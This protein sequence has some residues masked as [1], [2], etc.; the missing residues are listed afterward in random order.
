[1]LNALIECK[2][3]ADQ[4]LVDHTV[5]S[6]AHL[7]LPK[8]SSLFFGFFA[9]K[10]KTLVQLISTHPVQLFIASSQKENQSVTAKIDDLLKEKQQTLEVK[11]VK[12]N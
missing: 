11:F 1:M 6:C 9:R 7:Q 8:S 10:D 2:V 5:D 3:C 4:H 12:S